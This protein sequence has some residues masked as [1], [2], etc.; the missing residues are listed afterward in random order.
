MKTKLLMILGLSLAMSI[1]ACDLGGGPASKSS[2]QEQQNSTSEEVS[3]SN[4][5]IT[6]SQNTSSFFSSIINSSQ[7]ISSS[8]INSSN[9]QKSSSQVSSSSAHVHTYGDLNNG[10][11]PS[12]F[13]DGMKPYYYCIECGQYFDS[14]KNPTT[15]DA[16]KLEKANDSIALLLDG[17]EKETFTLV[18]K[19]ENH[20]SW[21]ITNRGVSEGSVVS[22][23][24]PGDT[25]YKYGFYA[26]DN[27]DSDNKITIDGRVDFLLTA[28]PNGFTLS[29]NSHGNATLVVKVNDDEYQLNKVTYAENDKETYIYGYHYFNVGD[30]MTVVDKV[31]NV[32]YG[33]D[34]LEVDVLWNVYDFEKGTNNEIVF[35]TQAR[36]GIEFDRGGDKKISVTKTFAPAEDVST[37]RVMSKGVK[38][39]TLDSTTYSNNSLEYEAFTWYITHEKVINNEDITQF[40]A[41]NGLT[42]YYESIELEAGDNIRLH[43]KNTIIPLAT[44][45]NVVD[46]RVP[47]GAITRSNDDYI[48][49][50]QSGRYEI[51]Y[52]PCCNS[53]YLYSSSV[54]GGDACVMVG[55]NSYP[56][57]KDANN[58]VT[59]TAHFEKNQYAVFKDSSNQL[60]TPNHVVISL[61]TP[62]HTSSYMIYFDKAGTFTLTLNLDTKNLNVNAVSIDPEETPTEITGAYLMGSGQMSTKLIS[63]PAYPDELVKENVEMKATSGGTV[64]VTVYKEDLSGIL[65]GVTLSP[66]S[67]DIAISVAVGSASM[68]YLTAG[69]G[70]YSFYLNKKTLVLRIVKVS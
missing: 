51:G 12:Y 28:T 65:D 27:I 39:Y 34:D 24:K 38:Q 60:I 32:I 21:K 67:E 55:F 31:N 64:Y 52:L 70:T 66:D 3:S 1:T 44:F 4:N 29:I 58:N 15:Q 23:A 43:Q 47:E 17:N 20:A 57:T 48:M 13:Y 35:K 69:P 54:V 30:K 11:L 33:F 53:I 61:G 16:L 26:G 5:E 18:E 46:L 41:T 25:T 8:Q 7:G 10:Y 62:V 9:E 63:N 2:S 68:F 22:I 42:I 50:N 59:Y 14:N 19:D 56:L 40:L 45:S 6:S 36:F 37:V 49:V